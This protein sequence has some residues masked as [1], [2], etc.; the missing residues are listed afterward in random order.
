MKAKQWMVI[1]FLLMSMA[2]KGENRVK[3]CDGWRF[4]L[5]DDSLAMSV[6]Y[7]DSRWERVLLPH[8]WSIL[9]LP[10]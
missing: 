5:G 8:D 6:G 2:V 10:S 4:L 1:G 7:D 3:M 9:Q